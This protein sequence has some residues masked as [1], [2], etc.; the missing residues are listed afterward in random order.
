M[1]HVA[2]GRHLPARPLARLRRE[3]HRPRPRHVDAHAPFR[4]RRRG[5]VFR[6]TALRGRA[7]APGLGETT[8]R[9]RWL[10]R[11]ATEDG[12][13]RLVIR[14]AMTDELT[15]A[16]L[17]RVPPEEFTVTRKRLVAH[18]RETGEAASAAEVAKL[19]RPTPAVWAI[20]QAAHKDR[21]A[22]EHLLAAADELKRA[23]LGRGSTGVVPLAKAYQ[24]A[25]AAL[26]ERSLASFRE[27][28][29]ATTAA[30]R[31][32][33]TGT[34]MAASTDPTAPQ[35]S[36]G[37]PAAA[38]SGHGGL[39]R[40]RRRAP[41]APSGPSVRPGGS[42]DSGRCPVAAGGGQGRA[43][44]ASRVSN[45]GRD[46]AHRR[47]GGG[48]PGQGARARGGRAPARRRRSSRALPGGATRSRERSYRACARPGS[49]PGRGEVRQA[50]LGRSLAPCLGATS[51]LT[52]HARQNTPSRYGCAHHYVARE[53]L[54]RRHR[55]RSGG[56]PLGRIIASRGNRT[57]NRGSRTLRPNHAPVMAWTSD[58][59]R[60]S[61][62]GFRAA[63]SNGSGD[64]HVTIWQPSSA[65]ASR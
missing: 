25:V 63:H 47:G 61:A 49:T 35:A 39:R 13:S 56:L 57:G 55:A 21:P 6:A 7:R 51:S 27:T 52:R 22:V 11:V 20:N 14:R 36:S 31:G 45:A 8:A 33:V 62:S 37:R 30:F 34:L 43:T 18:L 32:R 2:T 29:R 1:C 4:R 23:Q 48:V 26:T 17:F 53:G 59:G 46:R 58:S 41:R 65:R 19:P 54:G 38:R 44:E 28:G 9:S 16:R 10:E 50:S 5:A 12:V 3:K 60:R 64:R 40:L 42:A 15:I 24:G